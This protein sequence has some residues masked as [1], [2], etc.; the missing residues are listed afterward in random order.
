MKMGNCQ[1][2]NTS[3]SWHMYVLLK[4]PN[5]SGSSKKTWQ[6]RLH[7]VKKLHIGKKS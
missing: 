3:T 7:E 2:E 4:D 1:W 5:I 6:I